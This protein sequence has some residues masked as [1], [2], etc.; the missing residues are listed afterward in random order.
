MMPRPL[1]TACRSARPSALLAAFLLASLATRPSAQE[2]GDPGAM[3]PDAVHVGFGALTP[4]FQGYPLKVGGL[5][6]SSPGGLT[7]QGPTGPGLLGFPLNETVLI[8]FRFHGF[9][10][11]GYGAID[12]RFGQP[13]REVGLSWHAAQPGACRVSAFDASGKLL[14]TSTAA[15]IEGLPSEAFL[16][17]LWPADAIARVEIAPLDPQS[18]WALGGVSYFRSSPTPVRYCSAKA[19]SSGCLARVAPPPSQ[20]VSGLGDYTVL[21]TGVDPDRNGALFYSLTGPAALPFAGGTLCL[22]APV[23]RLPVAWSG[24]GAGCNGSLAFVANA[25]ALD[26]GPGRSAW[27][28]AVIRDPWDPFRLTLSDAVRLDYH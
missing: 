18:A 17:F 1:A 24:A 3:N 27:I 14:A 15:G 6:L 10:S 4:G 2:S 8:P 7:I 20:P 26:P 16:A 5:K 23:R 11:L 25:G 22:A 28:Q 12:V 9:P 13:V 19:S 21:V